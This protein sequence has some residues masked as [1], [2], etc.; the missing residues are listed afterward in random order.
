MIKDG[1]FSFVLMGCSAKI[2][3][4]STWKLAGRNAFLL[5]DKFTETSFVTLT[6]GRNRP[7][8]AP[9]PRPASTPGS[10]L[11]GARYILLSYLIT[12]QNEKINQYILRDLLSGT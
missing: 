7:V 11:S 3:A 2:N 4:N 1:R 12:K 9:K 8:R 5:K 10:P 6:A